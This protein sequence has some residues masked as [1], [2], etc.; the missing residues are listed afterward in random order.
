MCN[1]GTKLTDRE[2]E[3]AFV[4]EETGWLTNCPRLAELLGGARGQAVLQV[5]M[6][7][8]EAGNC[9]ILLDSAGR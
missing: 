2:G 1:R 8:E 4:R 7:A 6:E 9:E 5:I 3:R